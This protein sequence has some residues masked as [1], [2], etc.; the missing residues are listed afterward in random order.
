MIERLGGPATVLT[1]VTVAPEYGA[2][3]HRHDAPIGNLDIPVETDHGRQLHPG[4]L[5][6]PGLV[7]PYDNTGLLVEDEHDRPSLTNDRQWLEAR[8]EY[9]SSRHVQRP[10][11]WKG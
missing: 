9:Q 8:I 1:A 4:R 11:E 2:T 3:C 6:G 5:G 7:A 10:N